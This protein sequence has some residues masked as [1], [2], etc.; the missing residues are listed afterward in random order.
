MAADMS[1][2]QQAFFESKIGPVLVKQCFECPSSSAK[3]I[4]GKPLL[5]AP[6]DMSLVVS[7]ARPCSP[8]K[9]T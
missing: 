1:L 4:G 2:E 8:A 9:P 6:A 3:K 5:D 7:R